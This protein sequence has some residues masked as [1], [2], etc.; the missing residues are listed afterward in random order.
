MTAKQIE[1]TFDALITVY[2]S[3][4]VETHRSETPWNCFKYKEIKERA[5]AYLSHVL[6]R[7]HGRGEH[8]VKIYGAKLVKKQPSPGFMESEFELKPAEVVFQL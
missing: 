6:D 4:G 7:H 2:T 5:I 3:N 8:T 1:A